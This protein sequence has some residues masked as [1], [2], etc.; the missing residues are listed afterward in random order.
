MYN[1]LSHIITFL[2][3]ST[4]PQNNIFTII[5]VLWRHDNN[6]ITMI[7]NQWTLT[8]YYIPLKYPNLILN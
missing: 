4:K 5:Q 1:T 7:H 3:K 2:I 6:M 8:K